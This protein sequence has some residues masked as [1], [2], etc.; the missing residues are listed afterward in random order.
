QLTRRTS[1]CCSA[2]NATSFA[3]RVM[4]F[5]SPKL[6]RFTACVSAARS[7]LLIR[8]A[9]SPSGTSTR[10][11]STLV[12]ARAAL[13]AAPSTE[14]AIIRRRSHFRA[15]S[16]PRTLLICVGLGQVARVRR[17]GRVA[18]PSHRRVVRPLM[19]APGYGRGHGLVGAQRL[20]LI[21]DPVVELQAIVG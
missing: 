13:G 16:M 3:E 12:R 17:R 15:R 2:L 10:D 14:K 4:V 9:S 1:P 20:D 18:R 8:D 7:T 21:E 11:H 5:A 19:P 6:V